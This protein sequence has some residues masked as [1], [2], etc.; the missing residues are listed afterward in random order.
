[1]PCDLR[2]HGEVIERVGLDRNL[3]GR[4]RHLDS[5]FKCLLCLFIISRLHLTDA[6]E[7]DRLNF[8][9]GIAPSPPKLGLTIQTADR[10]LIVPE[11]QVNTAE[12]SRPSGQALIIT[13]RPPEFDRLAESFR[14]RALCIR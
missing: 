11:N 10:V 9:G 13:C 4:A 6:E 1:M 5:F 8:S 2:E 14:R 3:I 7:M 12:F